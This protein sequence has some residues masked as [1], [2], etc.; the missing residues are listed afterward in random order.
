MWDRGESNLVKTS[1]VIYSHLWFPW[2]NYHSQLHSITPWHWFSRTWSPVRESSHS[3]YSSLIAGRDF[4]RSL[5]QLPAFGQFNGLLWNYPLQ[6]VSTRTGK[7]NH[8]L[9]GRESISGFFNGSLMQ[10]LIHGLLLFSSLINLMTL[11]CTLLK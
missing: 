6:N 9:K 3:V 2:L 10:G 11:L 1:V 5:T 4:K 7:L 8:F